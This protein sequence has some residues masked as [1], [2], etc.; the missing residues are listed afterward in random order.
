MSFAKLLV[1]SFPLVHVNF[2]LCLYQNFCIKTFKTLLAMI[3]HSVVQ[4]STRTLLNAI[5]FI[6][7]S[8]MSDT[9]EDHPSNGKSYLAIIASNYVVKKESQLKSGK[10]HKYLTQLD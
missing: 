10:L 9:R 4:S 5:L 7:T 3:A 8:T 2:N 6:D 1:T